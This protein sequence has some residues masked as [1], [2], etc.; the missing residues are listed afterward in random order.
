[1]PDP[2]EPTP[3]R[4]QWQVVAWRADY[5]ERIARGRFATPDEADVL[6][7]ELRAQGYRDIQVMPIDGDDAPASD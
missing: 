6:V 4:G 2:A 1:M 5:S 3:D 7:E